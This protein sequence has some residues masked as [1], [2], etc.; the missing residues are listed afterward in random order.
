MTREVRPEDVKTWLSD[1][2][3]IAFFDVREAGQFGEGHPFFAIPLP[4]SVFESRLGDLAPNRGVRMVLMDGGDGVAGLAAKRAVACGYADVMVMKGGAPAWA[5]AGYTLYEGVNLPSKTFGEILEIKRHTPRKSA[6]EVA[7]MSRDG[8]DH[9]IV[10][11]RPYAEYEKFNIPG[12][13]CCPNGE[14]AL[15]IGEIAPDPKTTIVV[16]CAGRT[17]SILGAQTLIDFGVP[18]PVYALENGTQG[19]F[20]AGMQPEKGADRRYPEAPVDAAKRAAL[21]EKSRRRAEATGVKFISADDVQAW[22]DDT[23]RTTYVFDVRTEE[24]YDPDRVVGVRHAP[25]GQLVQ[26]TDQWVGVKGARIVLVDDDLV[27]A[28]MVANWLYQLGHDVAVLEGGI[29]AL[30]GKRFL[31]P[32]MRLPPEPVVISPR[33]LLGMMH[34]DGVNLVDLRSSEAYRAGHIEGAVWSIRPRLDRLAIDDGKPT[35]LIGDAMTAA[36]AAERLNELG[37]DDARRLEGD[38]DAWRAAGHAI[39][40]TPDNPA[41]NERIDFLFHTYRRQNDEE[42][43][44]QYLSWETGLVDQLDDQERASFRIAAA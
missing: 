14:L 4:Y 34:G 35:V 18:N 25:G 7:A 43:A 21:R 44:R 6:E 24:E 31:P 9:V 17:R 28:P 27:R 11:G 19:W 39:V 3:E 2:D 41:D 10:D 36:L 30:E 16:N 22:W 29:D 20:L 15:R 13:I 23:K 32:P 40:E 8:T 42:H 12:G 38:V 5:K 33:G 37:H 26:A 1:G